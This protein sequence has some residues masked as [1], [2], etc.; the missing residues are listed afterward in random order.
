MRETALVAYYRGTG[1][2]HR[3]RLLSDIHEFGFD[4]LESTHDY[5]QWLFPLPEPSGANASAPLLSAED[6][7]LFTA[8][9]VLRKAL[10]RSFELMLL[11]FGFRLAV[12]NG[13]ETVAISKGPDFDERR[14]VWLQGG[15]HNFLRI[16][17]ILRS[18]TLLGCRQHASAFL[19]LLEDIYAEHPGTIGHTTVTFWRRAVN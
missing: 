3:G 2:D 14:K 15:N 18:L 19:E 8:D 16:T 17:R 1:P 13:A 10:L 4:E 6:M 12:A 11:F 9:T 7:A 5:I